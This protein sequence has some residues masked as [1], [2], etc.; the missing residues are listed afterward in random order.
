MATRTENIVFY[1]VSGRISKVRGHTFEEDE[2]KRFTYDGRRWKQVG[3][4]VS[5]D[6]FAGKRGSEVRWLKCEEARR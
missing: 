1:Y 6:D 4:E 2:D 3:F 5:Y